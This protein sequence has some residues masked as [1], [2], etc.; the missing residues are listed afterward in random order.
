M[1]RTGY[2][3][4]ASTTPLPGF[5]RTQR[6]ALA[7]AV[8]VLILTSVHHVY[9]AIRYGTPERYHAVLIAALAGAGILGGLALARKRSGTRLGSAGWWMFWGTSAGVAVVLFG[10]VEGF[11]NHLLKVAL[12]LGGL[13]EAS[14]RRLYPAPTYELPNDLIFE[15]T[16]VLQVV[17]AALAGYYLVR[18]LYD[19]RRTPQGATE[20]A[21]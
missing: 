11:Y 10:V 1:S 5:L 6:R 20:V 18:L 16:G 15:A 17:P 21:S 19:H 9:G 14:L 12:Y 13:P 8:A 3:H 2:T 7:A 4:A